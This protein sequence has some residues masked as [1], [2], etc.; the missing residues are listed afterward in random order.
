M[1]ALITHRKGAIY[2]DLETGQWVAEYESIGPD[3]SVQRQTEWF[4]SEGDAGNF[5]LYGTTEDA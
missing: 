1:A 4:S 3:G 5:A 2:L